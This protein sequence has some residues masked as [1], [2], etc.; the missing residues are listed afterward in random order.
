MVVPGPTHLVISIIMIV[1]RLDI[2]LDIVILKVITIVVRKFVRFLLFHS[3]SLS[4]WRCDRRWRVIRASWLFWFLNFS[5]ETWFLLLTLFLKHLTGN[6]K[7]AFMIWFLWSSLCGRDLVL[8][9][10][11][12][13]EVLWW[14][15]L[16]TTS[17]LKVVFAR[18]LLY[19]IWLR[20]RLLLLYW[21]LNRSSWSWSITLKEVFE[22]LHHNRLV[23][24]EV[25]G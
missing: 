6:L 1:V 22:K 5:A 8:V 9:C 23:L 4:R 3:C 17:F 21:L 2:L 19:T 12:T 16:V 13:V 25:A 11:S 15:I 18:V 7:A 24:V 14:G 20:D 10:S